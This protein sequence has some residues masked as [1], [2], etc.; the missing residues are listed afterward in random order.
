[1][2]LSGLVAVE[3]LLF[4]MACCTC[5][6]VKA[7]VWRSSGCCLRICRSMR[8]VRGVVRY[9]NVLVNWLQNCVAMDC[10]LVWIWLLKVIGWFGSWCGRLPERL[11][12]TFQ[13][14][15]EF[16]LMEQEAIVSFHVCCILVLM[17][18]CIV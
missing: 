16:W 12:K 7:S 5:A 1:M 6:V 14:L 4:L 11:L 9:L 13:F 17:L 2:S 8:L 3:L 18:D 15:R 10:G